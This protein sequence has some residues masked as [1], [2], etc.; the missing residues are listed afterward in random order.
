MVECGNIEDLVDAE[1]RIRMRVAAAGVEIDA[2]AV[3]LL[4]E[5]DG[6]DVKTLAQRRRSVAALHARSK[7]VTVADVR[8]IAG[9]ATLQDDLGAHQRH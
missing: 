2:P 4:A 3:R 8:E 1:R 6:V 9:P 5:R 7:N